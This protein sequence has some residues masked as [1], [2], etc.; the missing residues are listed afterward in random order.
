ME[1]AGKKSKN[2]GGQHQTKKNLQSIR[3]SKIKTIYRIMEGNSC[4]SYV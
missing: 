1:S 4:K 3:N 2:R